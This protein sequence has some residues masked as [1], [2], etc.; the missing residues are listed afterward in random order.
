MHINGFLCT[1]VE[2]RVYMQWKGPMGRIS[3][4]GGSGA[5]ICCG[6]DGQV[7]YLSKGR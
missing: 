1:D 6:G 5:G 4:G 2:E 7:I 3:C